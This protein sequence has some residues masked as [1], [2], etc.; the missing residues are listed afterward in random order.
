M[1]VCD[2]G[3]VEYCECV[4]KTGSEFAAL[5]I[6]GCVPKYV[7]GLAVTG[8]IDDYT[9]WNYV[10]SPLFPDT[11]AGRVEALAWSPELEEDGNT[12]LEKKVWQL[13]DMQTVTVLRNPRWWLTVGYPAYVDFSNDLAA[14][15][16]DPMF[17]APSDL[18]RSSKINYPMFIDE[19]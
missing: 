12:V 17:L 19:Y 3:A 2:V 7:G 6:S 10:Y 4:F 15:K 16:A 9:S 8:F 14:A 18:T 11:E 1:E 13:A 5:D